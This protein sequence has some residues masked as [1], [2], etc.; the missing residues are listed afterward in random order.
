M[1]INLI[2]AVLTSLDILAFCT[3]KLDGFN[4]VGTALLLV[5]TTVG[6]G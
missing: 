3:L 2:S 6:V 5:C 4:I 1:F